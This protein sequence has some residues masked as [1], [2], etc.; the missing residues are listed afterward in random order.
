MNQEYIL[1]KMLKWLAKEW[2]NLLSYTGHKNKLKA[3][4]RLN[5]DLKT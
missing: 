4:Y 1:G 2:T 5:I 3:D